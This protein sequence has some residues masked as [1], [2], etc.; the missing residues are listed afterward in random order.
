MRDIRRGGEKEEEEERDRKR[1]RERHGEK[2]WK[3]GRGQEKMEN[4]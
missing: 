1:K 2:E 3:S 4:N